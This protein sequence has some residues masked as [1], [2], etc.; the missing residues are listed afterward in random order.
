MARILTEKYE[1]LNFYKYL[2]LKIGSE[3]VV[4]IRR[5]VLCIPDMSQ[6]L[7]R[8]TISSGSK[9]EGLNL[10]GSDT[11]TMQIDPFFKVYESE[12]EVIYDLWRIPLIMN[13]EDTQPCFTQLRLLNHPIAYQ[14]F[15]NMW[16]T[17]YLAL[18]VCFQVNNINYFIGQ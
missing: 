17:S 10:K 5:F 16:Q 9:G 8:K 1:S 14:F 15:K 11:D 3:E 7:N 12:K 13:T 2:C 18:D 6:T 4:R